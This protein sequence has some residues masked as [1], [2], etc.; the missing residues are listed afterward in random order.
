MNELLLESAAS[1]RTADDFREWTRAC[2]RPIFPHE[3]LISG[4]GHFHAGGVALDY[5]VTID[6]PIE[7]IDVI[8][9]HAGAIDTPILRRWLAVQEPVLFDASQPWP[10]VPVTWLASF[11][12]HKLRNLVAH[13]VVDAERSAG[14]YHCFFQLPGTPGQP[15]LDT[16]RWLAPILHE[17][18]CRV[19]D[20]LGAGSRFARGLTLLNEREREVARWVGLGKTN[21]EIAQITDMS[22][23][24]VK[25]NLTEIFNKLGV[26][27]RAQ[28]LRCLLENETGQ[29]PP[30]KTRFL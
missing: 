18:L 20:S 3:S 19:I 16:V 30:Y 14:T 25:H 24:T 12:H 27:N 26:S 17:V 23:S 11:R 4:W 5:L 10:D 6:F 29:V 15:H 2:I 7:H 8:R 21:P 28:L 1:V 13:A 22:E 9:N